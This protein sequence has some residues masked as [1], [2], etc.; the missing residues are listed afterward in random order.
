MLMDLNAQQFCQQVKLE[1]LT[2][3]H[4]VAFSGNLEALSAIAEVPYFKEVV[5]ESGNEVPVILR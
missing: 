5:N 3:L 2:L 4:H 1:E